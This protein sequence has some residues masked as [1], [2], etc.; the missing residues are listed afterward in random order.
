MLKLWSERRP[1]WTPALVAVLALTSCKPEAPTGPVENR[2]PDATITAP[3]DGAEFTQGAVVSFT[4]S[5]TDPEDGLLTGS[6]LRWESSEDGTIG[7]GLAFTR[8]NL[9]LGTHVIRLVATDSEGAADTASVEIGVGESPNQSPTASFSSSCTNLTCTFTDQST[10][11]DGTVEAWSWDFG[12]DGTSEQRNPEHTFAAGGSYDVTLT[13]TDDDGATDGTMQRVTVSPSN[14]GPTASFTFACS[15][16]ECAFTDTSTDADG[17]VVAWG[18]NFGDDATSTEQNPV[19]VFAAGGSYTVTLT[20]TDDDGT[21]GQAVRQVAANAKPVADFSFACTGLACAFTDLSSDQGGTIV[22][23]SWQFGDG[24]GSA[25][26][27]PSHTYA[28]DGTYAVRLIVVDNGTAADTVT[29]SVTVA[30]LNQPPTADFSASCP[31]LTCAFTD[32]STDADGTVVAWSWKFGDSSPDSTSTAQNPTHTYAAPGTY[33]V[34]LVVTDDD[35]ATS[36]PASRQLTVSPANQ[37]PTAE[38]SFACVELVCQFTDASTDPD[39]TIASRSW[40]FG[41]G[42][43]S[44]LTNPAHAYISK[45]TYNVRLQVTDDDGATGEVTKPVSVNRTPVVSITQPASGTVRHVGESVLFSGTGSDPDSDPLTFAWESSRDGLLGTGTSITR[46]DLTVGV[47]VISFIGTDGTA[48]DTAQVTLTIVNDPPVAA[49]TAPPTGSVFLLGTAVTFSGSATDTESGNLVGAALVWTSSLA[50]EL[51]TGTS[52][53]RTD[54]AA[55]THVIR[56]I[57]TDPQGAADTASVTIRVNT[58]PTATITA[59][60]DGSV[61]VVGTNIS[62]RGTGSDPEDGALTGGSIVWTS[63]INGEFGAG[64]PTNENGLSV[65]VHLITLTATDSDGATGSDQITVTIEAPNLSPTATIV[66]PTD[67]SAFVEGQAVSFQGSATDPEDGTLS[68]PAL[69]WASSL[70]G[71]IGSGTSFAT[72]ALTVGSHTV[73]LVATDL[74]GAADTTSVGVTIAPPANVPPTADFTSSC[75]GLACEF[76]DASSDG[77]GTV[78][79]W[80]WDFGDGSTSTEQNPQHTYAAGGTVPVSLVVTDD[81]GADSD[82]ATRELTL[83]AATAPGPA[84][85][86]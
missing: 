17:T 55:G 10:D 9:S 49:I 54:L 78:V 64:S 59:P 38:F 52:V 53:Q 57:A 62:F 56:L 14:Q 80:S 12:D 7:S 19:H 86:D 39:G 82:P 66:L 8:S 65:G 2:R 31:G 33:T 11:P 42:T 21:T 13:V 83:G 29:K 34:T 32:G 6:S 77:D 46:G 58:P 71:P 36:T 69:Q 70:D 37:G 84:G 20:V 35:G 79:A 18:W 81:D 45:G 61:F 24:T 40:S 73:R 63:S 74:D 72:A 48:A 27:N 44:A 3:L 60:A 26:T 85:L 5:A 22:S 43:N 47:H 51:G 25:Q 67:G 75:T 4:G 41:D 15:L 1:A 68:G 28:A 23:R 30:R 76:T 16:L 50:G